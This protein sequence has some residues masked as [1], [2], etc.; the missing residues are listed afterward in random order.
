M[1]A[2]LA[3]SAD[4]LPDQENADPTRVKGAVV[5][6]SP[7]KGDPAERVV[8]SPKGSPTRASSDQFWGPAEKPAEKPWEGTDVEDASTDDGEVDHDEILQAVAAKWRVWDDYDQHSAGADRR[9]EDRG[10]S[11]GS[12]ENRGESLGSPENAD[13]F[14]KDSWYFNDPSQH[15]G[16]F[17]ACEEDCV[18]VGPP[19]GLDIDVGQMST[20]ARVLAE[21]QALR[22]NDEPEERQA[23]FCRGEVFAPED[24]GEDRAP[25]GDD[26]GSESVS[27]GVLRE[28]FNDLDTEQNVLQGSPVHGQGGSVFEETDAPS[29]AR[30]SGW[31]SWTYLYELWSEVLDA[32]N[33]PH[34][35]N[36][37]LTRQ[38]E[39]ILQVDE[40]ALQALIQFV[41]CAPDTL[42]HAAARRDP[43]L[44]AHR[45]YAVLSMMYQDVCQNTSPQMNVFGY[46]CVQRREEILRYL[47][48]G[49]TNNRNELTSIHVTRLFQLLV[50]I[51]FDHVALT[52][53]DLTAPALLLRALPKPGAADLILHLLGF[54]D[55]ALWSNSIVSKTG[56]RMS[57]WGSNLMPGALID[58]LRNTSWVSLLILPLHP[59]VLQLKNLP[60][61]TNSDAGRASLSPTKSREA[62]SLG[63][64]SPPPAPEA[65]LV[66]SPNPRLP[67]WDEDE[68]DSKP[69]DEV[70]V[71]A[72]V[73]S[74]VSETTDRVLKRIRAK[75]G[76]EHAAFEQAREAAELSLQEL[77]DLCAEKVKRQHESPVSTPEPKRSC[78]ESTTTLCESDGPA[79]RPG[80]RSPSDPTDLGA[81]ADSLSDLEAMLNDGIFLETEDPS[82]G[83]PGGVAV[84]HHFCHAAD[85]LTRLLD[86]ATKG[87]KSPN[88]ATEEENRAQQAQLELLHFIFLE[89]QS[90]RGLN[91]VE[92]LADAVIAQHKLFAKDALRLLET[93]ALATSGP[94]GILVPLKG[95]MTDVIHPLFGQLV[96]AIAA[97]PGR[98]GLVET[99]RGLRTILAFTKL[100][101]QLF[102]SILDVDILMQIIAALPTSKDM[103]FSV[104]LELLELCVGHG[105]FERQELISLKVIELMDACKPKSVVMYRKFV[106][107]LRRAD[108]C[109][110]FGQ[111][112]GASAEWS[113]MNA[114]FQAIEDE[115]EAN[116]I[117]IR[118]ATEARQLRLEKLSQPKLPDAPPPP[119]KP[120]SAMTASESQRHYFRLGSTDLLREVPVHGSRIP[121]LSD[122]ACSTARMAERVHKRGILL[123]CSG[124]CDCRRAFELHGWLQ[125]W[126]L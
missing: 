63:S 92:I 57:I 69:A 15:D 95:S 58:C 17:G 72:V 46:L 3:D 27:A 96:R 76:A 61:H 19:P 8:L 88:L 49:V 89:S 84:V 9:D 53:Y 66:F 43:D 1:D 40:R 108:P 121:G 123:V 77:Y 119:P 99:V 64:A 55:G 59:L 87:Q 122:F 10:E 105:A 48:N 93:I 20:H 74:L 98:R 23:E 125:S 102:C 115:E 80:S 39:Q 62:G 97:T 117:P 107:A 14:D 70:D 13:K 38:T 75:S 30:S 34:I 60:G 85:L 110:C 24:L 101:P 81:A 90:S 16:D 65:R 73:C 32:W 5:N 86:L 112:L 22:E 83:W 35:D 36:A 109:S 51:D 12:P 120:V 78:D 79:A 126:Q 82:L 91:L 25:L 68:D 50:Q 111:W 33:Q 4:P 100:D 2:S 28:L 37:A 29:P 11:L 116:K 41:A 113:A 114:A 67:D 94:N 6:I 54:Q 124:A 103:Y 31:N 44:A 52:A 71:D 118:T 104:G 56:D 47:L 7:P 42:A 45:A 18:V 21:L 26:L 106:L